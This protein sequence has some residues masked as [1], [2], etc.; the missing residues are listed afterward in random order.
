MEILNVNIEQ[1]GYEGRKEVIHNIKFSIN[2]GELGFLIEPDLYVVDEPFVGLDPRA[3]KEFLDLLEQERRRGAAVLMSTHVLDTAE[4][5]CDRFILLNN[6]NI[7]AEG[8][9]QQIRMQCGLSEAS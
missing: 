8:E 3:T 2:R 9:L 5:I 4:K 7:V 6:G 1:A